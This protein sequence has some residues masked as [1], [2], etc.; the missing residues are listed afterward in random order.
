MKKLTVFTPTYNRA[1]CLHQ[2]YESLLR[3]TSMDFIWMIIDD[4]SEDDTRE[5]VDSWKKEN[6]IEIE[7]YYKENG[8]MHTGH[9]FAYKK[10]ITELNVC[11]DSDDYMPDNAVELIINFWEENGNESLAG[12]IGLD[13]FKDG[14]IVGTRIPAHLTVSKL[15]DL[16]NIHGVKGDKKLVIR[17]DLVKR[18]PSY[19]EYEGEKLV[20]LGILYLMIDQEYNFLCLNKPLC[21]VE[22]QPDGSSHTILKQYRVSPEG[23]AYARL[24]KI[25]L[26][27]NLREKFKQ[28]IHLVSSAIFAK[29]STLILKSSNLMITL[30][31]VPFGVFANLY[32]RLK[33]I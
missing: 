2:V 32:I 15:S 33:T 17:T 26:S 1:F 27:K 4:G 6:N 3:Q 25:K 20:P 5:L 18:F 14:S 13:Q 11:I 24:V 8:G 9:N 10:I 21:I 29:K 19:P 30:L 31:A 23:F 28:S 22:Y 12:I 16:Y 7:Y